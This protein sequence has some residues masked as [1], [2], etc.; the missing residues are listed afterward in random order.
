MPPLVE[1]WVMGKV[2]S[3]SMENVA[4]VLLTP[5]EFW[6]AARSVVSS[7]RRGR[8]DR[9]ECMGGSRSVAVL[10]IVA[11]VKSAVVLVL[12]MLFAL[13]GPTQG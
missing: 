12:M 1:T 2:A 4:R 5:V 10:V 3:K 7:R 13:R 11:S 9:R 6:A 8:T